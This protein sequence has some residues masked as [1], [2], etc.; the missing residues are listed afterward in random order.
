MNLENTKIHPTA[1]VDTQHIGP[2][3]RVWA[4][5]HILSG[6]KIGSSANI[7]DNCFVEDDVII[8]DNVTLKC[9]VFLWDG[10]T[11]END[12]FVGPNVSF[13]NDLHPRSGNK[14]FKRM[15]T[16]LKKGCSIGAG[17]VILPGITIGKY[18]LVGA[19]SVVTKNVGDHEL[20]YGNPALHK[21][22]VCVCG[23]KLE[24]DLNGDTFR[25]SCGISFAPSDLRG[26]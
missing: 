12:V 19:G 24:N 20:V 17:S 2:G 22:Y 8:G 4:F 25:C 5:V 23:M 7:C 15:T 18:A 13:S 26:Q 16:L 21:G 3:S 14:N 6:A 1:L 11:L 9:G 10:I